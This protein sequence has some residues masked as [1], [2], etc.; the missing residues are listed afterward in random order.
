VLAC[1]LFPLLVSHL[2]EDAQKTFIERYNAEYDKTEDPTKAEHAAW[3]AIHQQYEEDEN[4]VW[5]KQKVTA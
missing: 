3:E 1:Y 2:S 4:G 5:S